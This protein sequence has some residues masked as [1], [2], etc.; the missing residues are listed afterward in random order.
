MNC[1]GVGDLWFGYVLVRVFAAGWASGPE[2]RVGFGVVASRVVLKS[3][4]YG[5]GE[6]S[7]L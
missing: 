6:S 2:L 1:V 4:H 5:P 7:G 3:R